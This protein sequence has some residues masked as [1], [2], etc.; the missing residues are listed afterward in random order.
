MTP[1]AAGAREKS[2]VGYRPF[3]AL[4]GGTIARQRY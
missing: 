2:P 1:G 3:I 4:P